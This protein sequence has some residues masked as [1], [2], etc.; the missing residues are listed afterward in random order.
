M[1]LLGY[2]LKT[3]FDGK[4]RSGLLGAF[5]FRLP[6]VGTRLM[7]VLTAGDDLIR[8]GIAVKGGPSEIWWNRVEVPRQAEP[9]AGFTPR[10]RGRC[11]APTSRGTSRSQQQ[12]QSGC[13]VKERSTGVSPRLLHTALWA[14]RTKRG[15]EPCLRT[16]RLHYVRSS[17]RVR[18]EMPPGL[19]RQ[20]AQTTPP[21]APITRHAVSYP[22]NAS[23]V[24]GDGVGISM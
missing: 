12:W 19:R 5:P 2:E 24:E 15:C 11:G 7:V 13:P 1:F 10:G 6:P 4:C 20:L 8:S 21:E 17:R 16:A 3:I 9:P 22:D 18:Q 23:H 14:M